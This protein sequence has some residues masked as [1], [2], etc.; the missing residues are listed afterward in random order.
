M[1]GSCCSENDANL[2]VMRQR[3]AQMLWAVLAINAVMFSVEFGAGWWAGSTALMG[4]SLDMLGDAMV[5]ALSLFVV[6]KSLRWKAVSAGVKGAIML[7]F[8]ILVLG[9]AIHKAASGYAPESSLMIGIGALA[10]VANVLCLILLTRHREDDVNMRSSWV[11]SRNDL[12][13]N[14]GVI[15]AG[16]LVMTTGSVWPDVIVGFAIAVLFL[17]SSVGVLS[18]AWHRYAESGVPADSTA[19][20]T[21][22]Y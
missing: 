11:C 9:E 2:Q 16:V 20:E 8:G 14:S 12:F 6:A 10:L 5:Y 18:D 3:Q 22:P 17:Q 19:S 4:D 7:G 13:A 21:R 1:A 15:A